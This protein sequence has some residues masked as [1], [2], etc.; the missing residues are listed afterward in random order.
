MGP[1]VEGR[2]R[3]PETIGHGLEPRRL[4][5]QH[6]RTVTPRF[7]GVACLLAAHLLGASAQSTA[8]L[9]DK[10]FVA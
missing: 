2:I 8:G 6:P 4:R 3:S 7:L 5:L 1:I 9:N 10:T